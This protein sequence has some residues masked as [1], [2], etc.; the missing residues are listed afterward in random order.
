MKI[1]IT[2]ANGQL[3]KTFSEKYPKK[4]LC[5]ATKEKLDVTRQEQV[6]G[7]IERFKPDMVFHFASLTRG[8]ECAKNPKKAYEINVNGTRNIV[9]ACKKNNIALLFI[10]TNEIFDGIKKSAYTETDIPNPITVAGKTKYEAEKIVIENLTKYY[11]IRTSWLYSK[12][13]NNF[14]SVVL[15]TAKK[16]KR[17]KLVKD[18]V[19][20]PTYSLDLALAIKKLISTN[21]YGIY[22]LN[23]TGKASRLEFAKKAFEI[24]GFKDMEIIP[25]KLTDF[26][27]ISKPPLYTPL[28][29][30]KAKR[31]GIQLLDWENALKR[32]LVS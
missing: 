4:N 19:S 1:F 27:R 32:F 17:I 11:I 7:Q 24:V 15:N 13:A 25:L 26:R 6:L 22:H 3:G 10:S 14:L 5:L 31:L 12:W 9:E 29:N 16:T 18:E 23:N 28:S 2:G 20:S 21:K 30:S 8:D